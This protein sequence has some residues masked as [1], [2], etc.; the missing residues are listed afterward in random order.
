MSHESGKIT[1]T[2][3]ITLVYFTH[4]KIN[5][6]SEGKRIKEIDSPA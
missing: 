4:P 3:L 2:S 1:L 5:S 6:V